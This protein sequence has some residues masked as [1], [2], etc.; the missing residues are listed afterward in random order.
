MRNPFCSQ[1]I[2]R[3]YLW[4][5]L[6]NR[7]IKAFIN[8]DWDMVANDFI[9]QNFIGIDACNLGNPDGWRLSFPHLDA[10]KRS[11][12]KQARLFNDIQWEEDA[13]AALFRITVLR[14]IEILEDSALIHKKFFGSL[15]KADSN[16]VPFNWQTLYYCKK[17]DKV[18]K[19]AGF[20]GYIPHF[21]GNDVPVSFFPKQIPQWAAQ[22]KTAGPYSPVL[23]VDPGKLVVISGQAAIDMDGNV[24]GDNIESQTV[25][26]MENCRKQLEYAGCSFSDVF[27][28]NVYL[29]DLTDWPLFNEVYKKY[30]IE[31]LPV[32]T[33]VQ[34]GLLMTL[35]IEIEMWAVKS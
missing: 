15:L 10:Y 2:D 30:F 6:V 5:M 26:T 16:K 1:D 21:L 35:I 13:E 12:I 24:I 29:K 27:K 14:D 23:V 19:I 9:E 11:W 25:Y 3:H 18:W 17:V 28:V 20:T 8:E 4:D 32:R 7:D 33:A 22:H 31:P 34:T